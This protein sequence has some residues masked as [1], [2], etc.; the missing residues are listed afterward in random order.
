MSEPKRLYRNTHDAMVA[1]VCSGLA[2][3]MGLDKTAVRVVV[4]LLVVFT[5]LFPG[6]VAYVVMWLII[7]PRPPG[8]APVAVARPPQP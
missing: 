3:Y 1:G 6:V 5:A 7:P 4:A 8:T 2:D